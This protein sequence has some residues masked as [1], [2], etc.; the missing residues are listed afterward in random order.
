MV[1]RADEGEQEVNSKTKKNKLFPPQWNATY[2]QKEE[3]TTSHCLS[4]A[5]ISLHLSAVFSHAVTCVM[6]GHDESEPSHR[7]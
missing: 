6:S 2:A 1:S 5:A 4:T 7:E 3:G